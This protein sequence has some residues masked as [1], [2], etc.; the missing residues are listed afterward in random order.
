[1]VIYIFLNKGA[2]KT[3]SDIKY[4]LCNKRCG[5]NTVSKGT[6]YKAAW[7]GGGVDLLIFR[8][9]SYVM[10]TSADTS[11]TTTILQHRETTSCQQLCCFYIVKELFESVKGT[12]FRSVRVTHKIN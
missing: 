1:M 11:N 10:P 3:I 5:C 8:T 2:T 6:N 4:M 7:E 12:H 9:R